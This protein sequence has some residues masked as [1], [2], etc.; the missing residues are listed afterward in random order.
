MVEGDDFERR[1]LMAVDVKGYGSRTA[2]RQR[3]AQEALLSVLADSAERTGLDR[4]LWE[5]Q[6]AGDGELAVLPRQVPEPRV[7]DDFTRHLHAALRRYNR[8]RSGDDRLRLRMAVHHGPAI[9]AANGY[10]GAGP[11]RVAR[12]C[13]SRLL[14]AALD[15]SAADLVVA[16]SDQVFRDV[17]KEELTSL[18]PTDFRAVRI[19]EK[20]TDE[21]AWFWVPAGDVHVLELPS[22][23]DLPPASET[24]TE[25]APPAPLPKQ[26]TTIFHGPV[27]MQDGIFGFNE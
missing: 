22:P 9:P 3:E 5:R 27:T 12:L 23:E 25:A 4:A 19:V 6:G 21:T 24:R 16:L 2:R 18:E 8:G 11:V 15:A 10:G 14:K 26:V 1:L 7:V 13:D 20:E 17:V